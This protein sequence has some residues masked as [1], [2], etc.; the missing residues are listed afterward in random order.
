MKNL[1]IYLITVMLLYSCSKSNHG[2]TCTD[3][4]TC[5]SKV[6]GK[7]MTTN[8]EDIVT[9][10]ISVDE[11]RVVILDAKH[12][13][14]L[15]PRSSAYFGDKFVKGI[16]M[17][18]FWDGKKQRCIVHNQISIPFNSF[19]YTFN[20]YWFK[21]VY[22]EGRHYFYTYICY[23][24]GNEDQIKF[25]CLQDEKTMYG[26]RQNFDKI[27]VNGELAFDLFDASKENIWKH[28]NPKYFPVTVPD[29]GGVVPA[30]GYDIIYIT[31]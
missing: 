31:K 12:Q 5:C 9:G 18:G 29:N 10:G 14:R 23:P 2:E 4:E 8:S 15:D 7:S 26:W 22:E 20:L 21:P 1:V 17:F 16:K 6:T 27:W 3:P 13:D 25:R 19:H 28:Y 11:I 30:F 24:D